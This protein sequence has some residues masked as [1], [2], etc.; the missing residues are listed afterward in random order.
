LARGWERMSGLALGLASE[1]EVA[2]AEHSP[3][4]AASGREEENGVTKTQV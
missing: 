4:P 2:E 3:T 1:W